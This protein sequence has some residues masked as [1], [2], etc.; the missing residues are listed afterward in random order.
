MQDRY[1]HI[2]AR[3]RAARNIVA[4]RPESAALLRY[5]LS[6]GMRRSTAEGIWGRDFVA[7]VTDLLRDDHET[8]KT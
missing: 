7:A 3:L 8:T 5:S 2:A 1:N 6:R 4:A